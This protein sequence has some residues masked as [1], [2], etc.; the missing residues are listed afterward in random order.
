[1]TSSL[2]GSEMCIRDRFIPW[3]RGASMV[4]E[5]QMSNGNWEA[6]MADIV[7]DNLDDD[8]KKV[9]EAF[10]LSSQKLEPDH[11]KDILP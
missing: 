8:I 11:L 2:V 7:P 6:F 10:Y 1:M 9:H 5:M 4:M 3:G